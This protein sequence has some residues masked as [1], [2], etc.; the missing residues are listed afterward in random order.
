[1]LQKLQRHRIS[2]PE[3]SLALCRQVLMQVAV[4]GEE[5]PLAQVMKGHAWFLS[6][7]GALAGIYDEELGFIPPKE[8]T[9]AVIF[10]D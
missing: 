1:M 6:K 10:S 3:P 9:G 5:A 7:E 2:I 4:E 8:E